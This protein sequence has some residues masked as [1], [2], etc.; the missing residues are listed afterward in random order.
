MVAAL[1][2][3]SS[4]DVTKRGINLLQNYNL[5]SKTL[6]YKIIRQLPVKE[7]KRAWILV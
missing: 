5:I 1:I 4:S 2:N 3:E 7:M 6:L